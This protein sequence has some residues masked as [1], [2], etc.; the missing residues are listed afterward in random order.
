MLD[1]HTNPE[2][3]AQMDR[4]Y[5]P[6]EDTELL[7]PFAQNV[8][9]LRVLEIG[10]GNGLAALTAARGGARVVG[11]DLNPFALHRLAQIAR[12]E[13]L[14]VDVVRTDLAAGL[15]RFDRI[16]ANP[17]YLP[18][19]PAARDPDKWENLALDGGPDG[20]TLTVRIFGQLREHLRDDG[21]AYVLV[22]SRQSRDRLR[23]IR[24]RWIARGGSVHPVAERNLGDE[25]LNVWEIRP[26]NQR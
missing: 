12:E 17:P 2:F 26:P 25:L 24:D 20:C 4:V 1:R 5:L 18:T 6:R 11:T 10:C 13:G 7:L 8:G 23:D 16:L 3:W 21:V 19:P 9:G 14:S 22:S 15:G